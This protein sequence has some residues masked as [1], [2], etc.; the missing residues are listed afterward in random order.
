MPANFANPAIESETPT[1]P[2]GFK[3][4]DRASPRSLQAI[5]PCLVWRSMIGSAIHQL[6]YTLPRRERIALPKHDSA[7]TV[8]GPG[9]SGLQ[10]IVSHRQR[11]DL[12]DLYRASS[13]VSQISSVA[14]QGVLPGVKGTV[15][16][17]SG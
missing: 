17:G 13:L 15:G 5:P 14:I 3:P 11:F 9:Q 1:S 12:G 4:D 6:P 10:K 8:I 2:A 7:P 16:E